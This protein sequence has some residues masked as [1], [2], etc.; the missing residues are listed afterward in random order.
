MT[1]SF[2]N[3]GHV[4]MASINSFI[5]EIRGCSDIIRH[6]NFTV[7]QKAQ[8]NWSFKQVLRFF[9]STQTTYFLCDAKGL[10][11]PKQWHKCPLHTILLPCTS[12]QD[13]GQS[14]TWKC[15]GRYE[16]F[17]RRESLMFSFVFT[18]GHLF[19]L[20]LA[21]CPH[22]LAFLSPKIWFRKQD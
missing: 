7:R 2:Y 20:V 10:T 15:C 19:H 13:W 22:L 8:T 14:W 11:L 3:M 12:G 4:Y 6:R 18:L 21:F 1:Y 5:A 17:V 9:Q 16:H